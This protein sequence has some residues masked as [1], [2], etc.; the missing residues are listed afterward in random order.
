MLFFIE[1]KLYYN[2]IY[3]KKNNKDFVVDTSNKHIA[4]V[5][6]LSDYILVNEKMYI[7]D[8][9]YDL[10]N[11]FIEFIKSKSFI[12]NVDNKKKEIFIKDFLI[13]S[14]LNNDNLVVYK[15]KKYKYNS[16]KLYNM[17]LNNNECIT[18]SNFNKI[19]NNITV[20]NI[21]DLFCEFINKK[22]NLE[23]EHFVIY[24]KLNNLNYKVVKCLN[25][26]Y[27]LEKDDKVLLPP[28][29]PMKI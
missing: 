3:I 28:L 4:D 22:F 23:N 19:K 6:S 13:N 25:S 17:I 12:L 7:K 5:A 2:G 10:Y 14:K 16:I 27:N 8:N 26:F 29:M 9:Y 24:D 15:N 20:I 18:S 1:K 11:E 21:C